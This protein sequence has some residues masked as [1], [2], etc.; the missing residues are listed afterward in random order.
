MRHLI[1]GFMFAAAVAIAIPVQAGFILTT[2]FVNPTPGG[3]NFSGNL[4]SHFTQGVSQLL[5]IS[6]PG[7]IEFFFDGKEAG[8]TNSFKSAIAGISFTRTANDLSWNS[9]TVSIG[10]GFFN[11]GSLMGDWLFDSVQG[12]NN[13]GI[14][15]NAFGI[16]F[17]G[18]GSLSGVDIGNVVHL[19]FDDQSGVVDDNHDDL[20]ITAI[21]TPVPE[22]STLLLI[23]AGLVAFRSRRRLNDA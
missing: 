2:D 8:F 21:F 3:N 12:V 13:Q 16:F 10:S 18:G 7:T 11:S 9:Q 14:A 20:M 5:D 15:S 4:P 22:P 17:A 23:G 6:G 19:G 1:K